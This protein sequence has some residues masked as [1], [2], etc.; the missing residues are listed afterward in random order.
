MLRSALAT[1]STLLFAS[2]LAPNLS[3]QACGGGEFFFKNDVLA[4]DPGMAATSVIQG[5][6]E[7]EAAG[8]VFDVSGVGGTVRVRS[9]SVGFI[10]VGGTHGTQ[11]VVNLLIYDG[12]TFPGG[13][14]TFGPLVFDFENDVGSSI[15]VTSSAINTVDVSPY[16]VDVTSGKL[17]MVWEMQIN[18]SGDCQN[19][20]PANFAT[21]YPTGQANCNVT[22]KNLI[23]IQGI[24]WRDA[25]TATIGPIQL[26]PT[27]YAGNWLMRTCVSTGGAIQ[28]FCAGDGTLVTP[29]PCNNF[30]GDGRGC[31]N[32]AGTSGAILT[33][34]GTT[35]PDTIVLTSSGELPSVLGIFM[36]GNQVN[37]SGIRSGDGL[38]CVAG[39]LKRLYKK[40]AVGGVAS[41]P[42]PSDPSIT[43]Q[44]ALKGDPISPGMTRYYQVY[45]RD[46]SQVFCP[47]PTGNTWNLS[48]AI[49]ITW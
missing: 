36:Q 26:C 45:Y 46:P 2:L 3:A 37:Q 30:G 16:D 15:A 42:G 12:I 8:C 20:Y 19:G 25:A 49:Q 21:D 9:A 6:C 38:R 14:P 7:G 41:A 22:Q 23:Y 13:I 32:S 4:V 33:A 11:A 28:S 18:L 24:G 47:T 17:V 29:C 31:E 35:S 44:S 43:A 5:L 40:N 27:Y 34:S 10:Q 39:S 1:A 48:S